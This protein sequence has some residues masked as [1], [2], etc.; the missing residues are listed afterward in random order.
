MNY[1]YGVKWI[2]KA[3]RL[4]LCHLDRIAEVNPKINGVVTLMGEQAL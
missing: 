1:L 3:G 2:F 4:G